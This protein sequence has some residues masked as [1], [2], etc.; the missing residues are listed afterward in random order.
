M[1]STHRLVVNRPNSPLTCDVTA[2][3]AGGQKIRCTIIRVEL[4]RMLTEARD[5]GVPVSF[6]AG[7]IVTRQCASLSTLWAAMTRSWISFPTQV[8]A[9]SHSH[10]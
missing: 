2:I 5:A 3:R 10:H 9:S 8:R 4:L 7:L 6:E 1:A